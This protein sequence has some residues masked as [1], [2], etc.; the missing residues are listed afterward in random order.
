VRP[1]D[2]IVAVDGRALGPDDDLDARLAYTVGRR[3]ALTL[4]GPSGA[5]REAA[6]RPVGLAAERRLLYRAWVESRRAYVDSASGGRLGYVHMP[7]MSAESLA[8]L[9]ADLDAENQAK[10]G[11]VVDLRNNNGGFVNAYALDVFARRPYLTMRTRGRDAAPARAAL[12]Q[13]A[14]E[15]P[16]VLVTNQHSLSDAEDF[17]EGYRALGLG[18]VVG[19]PTAGWIIFT[20]NTQ[21]VDGTT[22]RLPRVRITGADGGDMER[23]PRPVDVAVTRPVGESYTGRDGQLDAAVRVLL[24]AAGAPA[25]GGR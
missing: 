9:Y 18:R 1:G 2:A 11:V 24:G 22:F 20:W 6:L 10:A 12:G 17:T 19:E 3:V 25:A 15:R 16:T 5:R 13:R 7:D 21:L 8:Q 4:A 14:L 23:R